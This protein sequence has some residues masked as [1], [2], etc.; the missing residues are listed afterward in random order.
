MPVM[1]G[2]N[3]GLLLFSPLFVF[4]VKCIVFHVSPVIIA[5]MYGRKKI[6]AKEVK[7]K[8]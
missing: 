1:G 2:G 8:T 6:Q 5:K 3:H 4:Y 7:Y